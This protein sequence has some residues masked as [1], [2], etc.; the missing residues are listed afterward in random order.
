MCG[1]LPAGALPLDPVGGSAPLAVRKGRCASPPRRL[2]ST[3][4]L[5]GLPPRFFR[6]WR[7]SAP[8]P[9][10]AFEKSGGKPAGKL[11]WVCNGM[12]RPAAHRERR[13]RL[14]CG[15]AGRERGGGWIVW[16]V[17]NSSGSGGRRA[18]TARTTQERGPLAPAPALVLRA[19]WARKTPPPPGVTQRRPPT[20]PASAH[21]PALRWSLMGSRTAGAFLLGAAAFGGRGAALRGRPSACQTKERGPGPKAPGH[22]LSGR[23]ASRRR[24]SQ[25]SLC[26]AA[27]A[28]SFNSLAHWAS[29]SLHP[30]LAAL[31][32]AP[33]RWV[34]HQRQ[35]TQ[36]KARP[37]V[38]PSPA[39]STTRK[40]VVATASRCETATPR[41]QQ[42]SSAAGDR[43]R[44]PTAAVARI[45]PS[46]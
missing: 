31:G 27:K 25:R 20:P 35:K 17:K 7:R 40:K 2:P 30:P 1:G 21:P 37:F 9:R 33:L 23:F 8:P 28:A 32:S 13:A 19:L 11:F 24:S 14:V 38:Q 18:R 44:P 36:Q 4:L 10:P 46:A 6:H 3:P 5:T 42:P 12:C 41:R 34:F 45:S 16:T 43:R 15:K 22:A 29:A 26:V 39:P